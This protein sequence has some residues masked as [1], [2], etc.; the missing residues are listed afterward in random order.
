MTGRNGKSI[1]KVGG[2]ECG[3]SHCFKA[4]H[5]FKKHQLK[6]LDKSIEDLQKI[7][8]TLRSILDPYLL[9]LVPSMKPIVSAPTIQIGKFLLEKQTS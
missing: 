5:E 2:V 8:F 7:S 3:K 9:Y 1:G 4:V 6:G